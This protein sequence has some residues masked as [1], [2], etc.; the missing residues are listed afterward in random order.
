MEPRGRWSLYIRD[1]VIGNV[2]KQDAQD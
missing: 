1:D 2:K